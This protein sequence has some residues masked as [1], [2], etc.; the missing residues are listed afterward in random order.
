MSFVRFRHDPDASDDS[1]FAHCGYVGDPKSD[2]PRPSET[3]Q[4]QS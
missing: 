3:R 2:V 4:D 1:D